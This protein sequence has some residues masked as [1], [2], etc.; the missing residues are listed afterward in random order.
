M[1]MEREVAFTSKVADAAIVLD[2]ISLPSLPEESD[3]LVKKRSRGVGLKWE[4]HL[5]PTGEYYHYS[6]LEEI[7]RDVSISHYGGKISSTAT[8]HKYSCKI[9]GCT[10]MRKY[11]F[12][13]R[14]ESF[15]SQ[16]YG[17]HEHPAIG[18]PSPD[19][20]GLT[21]D[22][23]RWVLE[24][25]ESKAYSAG[26]IIDC[27]VKKRKREPLVAVPDPDKRVLN[28]FISYYKRQNSGKHHPSVN[29]LKNWCVMH[30]PTTV[31]DESTFNT[32]FA[33][34]YSLVSRICINLRCIELHSI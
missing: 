18:P 19:Q 5:D 12:D 4:P 33:L 16:Y 15:I 11:I 31:N 10:Y 27:F 29:D 7:E 8:E 2:S 14:S 30:G 17:V 24:A 13:S 32:S 1:I 28:N 21:P 26:E 22:Q 20:R 34:N 6:N 9:K 3:E 23:R 25:F